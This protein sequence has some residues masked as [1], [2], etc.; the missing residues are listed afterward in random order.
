MLRRILGVT[1]KDMKRSED[2]R[3]EVGVAC[4][5]DK[6]R[7]ARL[8]WNGH[9]ARREENHSTKRVMKAKVCGQQSRGRQKKR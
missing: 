8:R 4:I 5:N 2:I 6:V 7:E 3:Q 1:L 9:V